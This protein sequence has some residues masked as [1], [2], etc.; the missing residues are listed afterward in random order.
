MVF[1]WKIFRPLCNLEKSSI[2]FKTPCMKR[3][4]F[5]AL[6]FV[7]HVLFAQP[8]HIT[9]ES[10]IQNV[11]VFTA[12]AQIQR[13]AT[14]L[15]QPGRS[16]VVFSGLS[17]QLEQQSLQ[18]KADAAITLLSVQTTRD[19]QTQRTIE[20]Q[21]KN[22]LL[23]SYELKDRL[24]SDAKLLDVYKAEE[25]MLIKNQTIGGTAGVKAA[26]LKDVL[27][28]QRQRLT[29]VYQKQLELQKRLTTEQQD[30]ETTRAQMREISKKRDSINYSVTALVESKEARAVK[31]QLWYTV[32]DAGWYPTYDV[33]VIEVNQPLQVL[34]NANVFQRSG[35]T[36]KD[37][38]LQISTG[39]PGDNATRQQLQPWMV[40]YYD[41]SVNWM[42][43]QIAVPGTATGRIVNSR[44]EPLAGVSIA[45]KGTNTVTLSDVNGFFRLQNLTQNSVAIFSSV[46]Y[47]SK[48]VALR[49]GYSTVTLTETTGNLDEVVVMGYGLEGRAAGV[50]VDA[51]PKMR[52]QEE[53]Q[54]VSLTTQYQPTAVV[55]KIDEKYTLETDG[56]TTTIGL[57]QFQMP[58]IYEYYAAPKLDPAAF[59][60]AKVANW[61]D[62]DLQSGEANLYFEGTS[63]GKTYIDLASAGDTLALSLGKDN[64]IRISRKLVKEYSSQKFIGSNR[65]ETK[66]YETVVRNNKKV[67]V[68]LIVEDQFPISTNKEIDVQETKA[69]E[70]QVNKDTGIATWSIT[71][72]PGQEKK[73]LLRYDVKYQKEKR[74]VLE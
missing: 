55:Y 38:A 62:Y 40:G 35:E 42:R 48:A 7:T 22:L 69:P 33:R 18:L 4:H 41:P 43:G 26:D 58:T 54:T 47:A 50:S 59:L 44:G 23:R 19:F 72:Q 21:E 15:V 36:W 52:K 67:A 57:K 5:L 68:T 64:G 34:M 30:L 25:A 10:A 61:Q 28:L 51:A 14:V 70:A 56:K 73:L 45:L 1:C 3:L 27:D 20:Q 71:L 2:F 66:Q 32:K 17:N 12:G 46:G 31:F 39:N 13:T 74:V 65:T 49:P 16:E 6:L 24:E 63:L 11:T 60:T 8:K 9:A 37:V 29:E 53:I